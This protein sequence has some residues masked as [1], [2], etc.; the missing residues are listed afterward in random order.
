MGGRII[1]CPASAIQV[2]KDY[3]YLTTPPVLWEPLLRSLKRQ[4]KR[5]GLPTPEL[6]GG[7]QHWRKQCQGCGR[8]FH[9]AS[10][11]PGHRYCSDDCAGEARIAR[12]T[13]QTEHRTE[14]RERRREG[15]QCPVVR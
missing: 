13:R 6:R 15:R 11:R 9:V 2:V 14:Q 10:G 5:L 3:F 12:V 7:W 4:H 1:T 8:A